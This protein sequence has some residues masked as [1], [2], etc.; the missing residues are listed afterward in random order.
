MGDSDLSNNQ[1]YELI[2]KSLK[3]EVQTLH[4]SL[5]SACGNIYKVGNPDNKNRPIVVEFTTTIKKLED[6]KNCFELRNKNSYIYNELTEEERTIQATLRKYKEKNIEAKIN[7]QHTNRQRK[8]T[9]V[10]R[11]RGLRRRRKRRGQR[12]SEKPSEHKQF[13]QG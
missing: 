1:L 12:R 8:G 9:I 5:N 11:G 13:I 7:T 2:S 4:G 6:P 10:R 3:K